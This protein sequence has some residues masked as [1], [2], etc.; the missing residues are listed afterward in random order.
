MES[1]QINFRFGTLIQA[2]HE[3]F[4]FLVSLEP[5]CLTDLLLSCFLLWWASDDLLTW[6][7]EFLKKLIQKLDFKLIASFEFLQNLIRF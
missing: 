3:F 4:I 2:C 7:S 5:K 6:K 1:L